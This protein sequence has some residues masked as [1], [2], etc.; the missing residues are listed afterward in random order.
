ML[1]NNV[2]VYAY[3]NIESSKMYIGLQ[4]AGK[5][6]YISSS[7]N[8]EFWQDYSCGLLKRS[9][10]YVGKEQD[11]D[12]AKTLEWFAL[13]YGTKVSRDLMYNYKNNAHCV[14]E[15]L[16]TP[17]MK[18]VIID[19]IEGKTEGIEIEN[20]F[21]D[22]NQRIKTI[23]DNIAGSKYDVQQ[24]PLNQLSSYSKNQVRV[25]TI[26]PHHVS[27][28]VNAMEE[29]PEKISELLDP[30]TV[31]VK[32]DGERTI[33]DGNNRTAA[34]MK[35]RGISTA[36]VIF[37]NESEFGS[38]EKT[39]KTNYNFF[40]MLM[41]KEGDKIREYNSDE[42]I[43]RQM[44]NFI[45]EQKLDISQ[46]LQEE[47]ARKL[48][49]D[50]F[51]LVIPSKKKLSGLFKSVQN[52][53][54]KTEASL[55]YQSN[56]IAY[57]DAFFERYEWENYGK[58]NI[59]TVHAQMSKAKHGQAFGYICRRMKNVSADKGAIVL[60][61]TSKME[62]AEHEDGSWLKD[63]KDTI[64]FHQLDIQVDVLPAFEE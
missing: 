60:H 22:E 54:Q 34:L 26:K 23:A 4:P 24:V 44:Q 35:V 41:N 40:G 10:I 17:E 28:L 33:L 56:I 50:R 21:A 12:T 7:E 49:Y 1:T 51:I 32:S 53:I 45:L 8:P 38:N 25:E 63:L 37:I 39:R 48:I 52:R 59:A 36:P 47:R 11:L 46:P 31:V 29:N 5:S 13:K 3:R 18:E 57:D 30:I 9:I 58:D 42:D 27:K 14:D 15:A 64:N 62:I 6:F 2:Y 61:Y 20:S 19:Y 16:I 55:K 43:K